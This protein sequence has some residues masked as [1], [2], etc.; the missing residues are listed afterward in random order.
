[1]D[2]LARKGHVYMIDR[3]DSGAF[4]F[5]SIGRNRATTFTGFCSEHDQR[6]FAPIDLGKGTGI[7]ALTLEQRVLFMLRATAM[8]YWKKMVDEKRCRWILAALRKREYREASRLVGM[9]Q[10]R[11]QAL[12]E[13]G[14]CDTYE[15]YLSGISKAVENLKE[16]FESLLYQVKK[17]KYALTITRHYPL[18]SAPRVA[19]S[20]AFT[21]DY[22][23]R[24]H[25]V[26]NYRNPR[27]PFVALTVLPMGKSSHILLGVHRRFRPAVLPYLKQLDDMSEQERKVAVSRMIILHCENAVFSPEHIDSFRRADRDYISETFG[28]TLH[29]KLPYR[30]LK[31][32]NFFS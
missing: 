6:L 12:V 5:V 32:V 1:M 28:A 11:V 2:M 9:P 29:D 22:D 25:E 3:D 8:E 17:R 16:T 14:G 4:A 27:V 10:E 18:T 31:P 24:G 23:F 13:N 15:A 7:D 20:S 30:N 26:V 19:V 21:P